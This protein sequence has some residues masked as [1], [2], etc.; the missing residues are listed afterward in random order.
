MRVM[1][2]GDS[3]SWGTPPD[4]TGLR[5]GAD[6]RWPQVMAARLGCTLVEEALPG[7]TTVHDDPDMLG[8][9]MNGLRHLPVALLSNAPLDLVLIML[10][11]ND[12]KARFDPDAAKIA[13]NLGRLVETLRATGAGRGPWSEA[14]A[15]GVALIT[16]M[17]LGPRADDPAWARHDEWRGG[18]AASKGLADALAAFGRREDVPVLDAG[19]IVRTSDDDPIHMDPAAHRALGAACADWLEKGP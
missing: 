15:P 9:A 1:V 5:M 12:C 18:R 10:G 8:P 3:N 7:R 19:T 16:P 13:A 14:P 11:T 2:F 17:P 6:V 4:G